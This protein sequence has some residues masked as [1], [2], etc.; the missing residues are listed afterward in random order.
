MYI[1]QSRV[2]RSYK[3]SFLELEW[4]ST[5]HTTVHFVHCCSDL[6]IGLNDINF[7]DIIISDCVIFRLLC[8][9][10]YVYWA[11]CC[12]QCVQLRTKMDT[13]NWT[14]NNFQTCSKWSKLFK[15]S[16]SKCPSNDEFS[17][18][19]LIVKLLQFCT[20][21]SST[22]MKTSRENLPKRV[23]NW[24]YTFTKLH[25]SLEQKVSFIL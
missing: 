14:V 6:R 2:Y 1:L 21:F 3:H 10:V 11:N 25:S 9:D 20:F 22:S 18:E 7:E 17:T 24:L 23:Q 19:L 5:L 15:C 16:N 12:M 8:T 13:S 4:H